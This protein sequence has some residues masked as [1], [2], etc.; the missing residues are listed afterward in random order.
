[1]YNFSSFANSGRVRAVGTAFYLHGQVG[2]NSRKANDNWERGFVPRHEDTS[3]NQ[4][5]GVAHIFVILLPVPIFTKEK[6]A[7]DAKGSL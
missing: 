6:L 2:S 3:A 1:M 4:N 7:T 5:S